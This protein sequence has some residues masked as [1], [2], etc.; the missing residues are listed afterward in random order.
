MTVFTNEPLLLTPQGNN[1]TYFSNVITSATWTLHFSHLYI[2]ATQGK[3][4]FLPCPDSLFNAPLK[5]GGMIFLA[6]PSYLRHLV[7]ETFNPYRL[8]AN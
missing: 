5:S 2:Y 4:L 7:F 1:S 6:M 8:T 3:K